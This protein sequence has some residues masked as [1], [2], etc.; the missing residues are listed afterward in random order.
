[1]ICASILYPYDE[2]VVRLFE[3]EEK[4]TGRAHY[5]VATD[6]TNIV[7][8]IEA[9]DA[10]ALRAALTTITKVLSMWEASALDGRTHGN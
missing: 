3:P 8:S 2:R 7:F 5:S 4:D 9:Q 1:M 10:T 6:G